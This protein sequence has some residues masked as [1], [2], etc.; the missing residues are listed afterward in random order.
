[1]CLIQEGNFKLSVIRTA[2][3]KGR[4]KVIVIAGSI[5]ESSAKINTSVTGNQSASQLFVVLKPKT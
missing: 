1:M 2:H 3:K 5:L 4:N